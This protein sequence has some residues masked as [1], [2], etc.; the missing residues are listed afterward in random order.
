[1]QAV[2]LSPQNGDRK[3]CNYLGT[4]AFAHLPPQIAQWD[5]AGAHPEV[6]QSLMMWFSWTHKTTANIMTCTIVKPFYVCVFEL[7]MEVVLWVL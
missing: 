7:A 1:M 5:F 3:A 2:L 6:S 4:L